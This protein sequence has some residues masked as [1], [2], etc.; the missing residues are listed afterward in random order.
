MYRSVFV[1]MAGLVLGGCA[2]YSATSGQVVIRDDSGV[3]NVRI[4]SRDR[5]V[6][7]RIL[8]HLGLPHAL[9]P[10]ARARAP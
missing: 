6:I 3:V 9:P 1:F 4:D 8:L 7:E 2:S 5:A 10:T